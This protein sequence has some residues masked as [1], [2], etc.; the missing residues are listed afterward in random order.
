MTVGI[1]V[2]RANLEQFK[3]ALGVEPRRRPGVSVDIGELSKCEHRVPLAIGSL[4]PLDRFRLIFAFSIEI[5]VSE[6][7]GERELCPFKSRIRRASQ[8]VDRLRRV[9]GKPAP[10]GLDAVRELRHGNGFAAVRGLS[11]EID[12]LDS[13]WKSSTA[14]WPSTS[15]NGFCS[16]TSRAN[17]VA[18]PPPPEERGE[19]RTTHIAELRKRVSEADTK[20]KRL[21]DAIENGIADVSDPMLKEHVTELK[22]IRDQAR[23]DAERAE[24]AIDRSGRASRRRPSRPLLGRPQAHA[25]GGGGYR[26]DDLRALAQRIEVDPKESRIMGSKSVLLRTLVAASSAKSAGFGVPSFVPKWRGCIRRGTALDRRTR[27]IAESRHR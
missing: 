2:R 1:S 5:S 19:R 17:P 13:I 8:I 24:G 26:R 7:A 4:V 22:A 6:P 27:S 3:R 15:S 16:P 20:L 14:S 23:L 11:Q 9:S 10:P 25:D 18:R 21:Y 12:R